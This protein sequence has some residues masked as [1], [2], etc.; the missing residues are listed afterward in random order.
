MLTDQ[1]TLLVL[2]IFVVSGLIIWISGIRLTLALDTMSK[3]F[4]FGEAIGG[5]IFLAFVT[6]LPEIAI[7]GI[8]AFNGHTEIAISNILGGIAIQTVVLPLID[9]FGVG[10]KHPLSYKASSI[11]L[12]LE[13]VMLCFILALVIMGKQL[14]PSL[15]L[16]H[17]NPIEWFIPVVWILGIYIIYK[18][19]SVKHISVVKTQAILEIKSKQTSTEKETTK[20]EA[21]KAVFIFSICAL[22]TLIAGLLLEISSEELAGR[23]G[24]SS[25]LFGATI[26]AAVT[27][28]PEITTGIE[29]AKLK[30]Y[31]MAVSDIL[32]GNAFLPVLL[33]FGTLIGGKSMIQSINPIEIYLTGLGILLTGIFMIGMIVKSRKQFIGFGYDSVLLIIVYIIGIIGL[34]FIS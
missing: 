6:N 13:G 10:K 30:D 31:Q 11:G 25:V 34:T 33:L 12:I 9:R 20:K 18:N 17:A 8:A 19:P 16:F 4:N 27:A 23:F 15:L 7:T 22:F 28:L 21:L 29:S 3:H 1:S 32:G 14:P 5:M 2:L 26:L 24:I